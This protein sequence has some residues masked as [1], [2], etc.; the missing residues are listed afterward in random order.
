MV[1]DAG[2]SSEMKSLLFAVHQ[3]VSDEIPGK[4]K[5]LISM[6]SRPQLPP[7]ALRPGIEGNAPSKE[8]LRAGVGHL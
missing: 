8:L 3:V 6:L 7:T 5:S 4:G 2:K 1:P